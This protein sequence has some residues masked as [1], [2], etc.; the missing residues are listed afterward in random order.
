[1]KKYDF[2]AIGDTTTDAFI[3]IKDARVNCDIND[4]H[5][6]I[7]MRFGDKIPYEEN[8]VVPAVGN[9]ANAATSATRLGLSTAFV[10]TI[11]DDSFGRETLEA[12][13][14]EGIPKEFVDVQSG[15]KTNY[16]YVLW[17]EDERTILIKH[18]EYDY[19]LPYIDSPGWVYFS[20]MGEN[21]LPFH[22]TLLEYLQEHKDI[23]LA[24]QP[25]TF[26][27]KFG[28]DKMAGLYERAHVTFYN[29]EEAQLILETEEE[30]MKELLVMARDLG[31]NIAV[32]TD[33]KDGAY[34]YDGKEMY[35]MPI[36]PDPKPPLERTGV[37][38]AF[39]SAFAAF[40]AMDMSPREALMRAPINSMNVAQHVGAREGLLTKDKI[41][42][43]LAQAPDGY[44]PTK[45]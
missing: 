14:E 12:L 11:G 19:Q 6:M 1:M 4:E 7:S 33:G 34:V 26:Q 27:M 16:H 20:S 43:Y 42:E 31:P 2:I 13:E 36:Y 38:D 32:V 10:T 28:K 29:K 3:R 23:K 22:G 8:Y 37:G 5:C 30:D 24:F 17:Y 45:L 41:E 44:E 25:G 21:S 15:K 39:S 40:L 35:H 9:A 18:E